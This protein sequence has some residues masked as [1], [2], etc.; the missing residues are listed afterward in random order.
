MT[1]HLLKI[2]LLAALIV[3]V[4]SPTFAANTESVEIVNGT[5]RTIVALESVALR[6]KWNGKDLLGGRV[7]KSGD[8]A[9]I[10][11]DPAVR[12]FRLRIFF[13]DGNPVTWDKI[14]FNDAWR[15]TLYKGKNGKYTYAKNSRG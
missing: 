11:Y 2:F 15:L 5:G 4:H 13:N 10:N 8:S 6:N 9:R 14:D 1:R 3:A 12:Y 7:L